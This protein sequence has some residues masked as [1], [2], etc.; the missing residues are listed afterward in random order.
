MLRNLWRCMSP[1]AFFMELSAYITSDDP[2]GL[3]EGG[4]GREGGRGEGGREG[5][6]EGGGREGGREGDRQSHK[7]VCTAYFV[8]SIKAKTSSF[9]MAL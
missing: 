1:N 6:R 7:N 3:L 4:G 8:D 2:S 5:G 9:T